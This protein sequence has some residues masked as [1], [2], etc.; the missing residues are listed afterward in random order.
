MF[1]CLRHFF[2]SNWLVFRYETR[3]VNFIYFG[4]MAHFV[5]LITAINLNM[6]L[7][8]VKLQDQGSLCAKKAFSIP[9]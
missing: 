1:V 7:T 4:Y 3:L 5:R 6:I 9:S 2:S 8:S